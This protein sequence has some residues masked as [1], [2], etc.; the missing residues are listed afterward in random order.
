ME[1]QTAVEYLINQLTEET[2]WSDD[3]N[4]VWTIDLEKVSYII[5]QAKL[6]EK[7]NLVDAWEDGAC[8]EYPDHICKAEMGERYYNETYQ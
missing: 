1:K 5:Q 2:I 8:S 7:E 4:E 3:S 6:L